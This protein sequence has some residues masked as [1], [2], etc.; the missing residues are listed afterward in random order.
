MAGATTPH[1]VDVAGAAARLRRE[2]QGG[3]RTVGAGSG[4]GAKNAP[5]CGVRG[6]GGSAGPQPQES[7]FC[8]RLY[9]SSLVP[10]TDG[11]RNCA[12]A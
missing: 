9:G 2:I 6:G 4:I 3:L 8:Q 10:S 12:G 7:I 11:L 1:A 5:G